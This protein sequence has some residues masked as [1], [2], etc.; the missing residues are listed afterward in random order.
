MGEYSATGAEL[1]TCGY[2]PGAPW[3]TNPLFVQ[4][5]GIYYYY[6]NDH[7]G[8]PQ[9]IMS[10][11]GTVVWAATY[12]SFGTA[13]ITTA[14]ITNNL[15]F[16]GQ[17]FDSESG[18]QY[19]WHRFYDPKR[20]LHLADPIGLDGGINLY[21]Y[22]LNNPVNLV[23]P[24]GLHSF[25]EPIDGTPCVTSCH[26]Q[27]TPPSM[28]KPKAPCE[29]RQPCYDSAWA[30][31]TKCNGAVTLAQ[32]ACIAGLTA[33]TEG[34]GFWAAFG[35]CSKALAPKRVA[36]AATYAVLIAGCNNIPCQECIPSH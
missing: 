24:L 33:G 28:P 8:T 13:T 15:R 35:I 36:C 22:A 14:T 25:P 10:D 31:F 17:Y 11:N 5:N 20:A 16:P 1:R 6:L 7:L 3:S 26:P 19:N 27:G 9:K 23:D 34:L 32:V 18:L 12:E 4:E 21:G 30:T 2:H 29:A